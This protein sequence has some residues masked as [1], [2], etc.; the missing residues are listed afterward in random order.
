MWENGARIQKK[1]RNWRTAADFPFLGGKSLGYTNQHGWVPTTT[2]IPPP[3]LFSFSIPFATS[4][5]SPNRVVWPLPPPPPSSFLFRR[6]GGRMNSPQ[7]IF[8]M[9]P[10][11]LFSFLE[12]RSN[13]LLVSVRP[14]KEKMTNRIGHTR[15]T[16]KKNIHFPL[17]YPRRK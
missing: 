15:K 17:W 9:N 2:L 14:P 16:R 10:P 13:F 1:W 8:S 7:R 12:A 5:F 11:L 4:F 6:R 3:P